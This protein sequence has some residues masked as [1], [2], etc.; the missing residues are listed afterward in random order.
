MGGDERIGRMY[1]YIALSAEQSSILQ[2]EEIANCFLTD[3]ALGHLFGGVSERNSL[4]FSGELVG[5]VNLL[6]AGVA[7]G[8]LV[9]AAEDGGLGGL[10]DVALNLHG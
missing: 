2:T 1:R 7:E 4:V 8:G 5:S 10:A 9:G 6:I 3:I